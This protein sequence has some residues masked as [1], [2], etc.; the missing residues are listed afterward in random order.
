[1]LETIIA[2][3]IYGYL[4]IFTSRVI[5]VSLDVF[6][7]LMLTRGYAL[8]AAV[9]GFFEVTIFVVALGTVIAGGL[10]DPVRIIAY[11]GGFATGNIIGSVIEERMAF[12]F[13]A[14]QMF[15]RDS[16]CGNLIARLRESNYG[17]TRIT[18]EGVSGPRDVLIVS[19]KRKN[20]SNIL[21][22]M[23]DVAPGTFFNI[24]D[25]RSIHGGI[26]PHRR[27]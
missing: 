6:R 12:G 1:M 17:V 4:F 2:N 9:I 14:I 23:N 15:P 24:S 3:P 7:L 11:A 19:A 8:V 27:P 13:V 5:D 25:I 18:G 10:S 22:T 16:C 26:F 20:L 21:K